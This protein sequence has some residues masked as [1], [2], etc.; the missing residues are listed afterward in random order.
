MIETLTPLE[1]GLLDR[2][3]RDFPL[4]PQPFAVLASA[5]ETDE[6][7]VLAHIVDFRRRGLISRVG[8]V[9]RPNTAGASTLAAMAV[10][11]ARL[12]AV[13][14]RVSAEPAVNHNYER[15]H[16]LNLW[17]VVTATDRAAVATVLA[18][19]VRDS[20]LE[21]LDL[22]L[23]RAY[24]IDLGFSL[25]ETNGSTRGDT[26]SDDV[27]AIE[28]DGADRKLLSVIE[29]GLPLVSRPFS[30][31]AQRLGCSEA[32]VLD[33]LH[34]LCAGG[35]IS[36]FGLIVRHRSL[37]YRA[38]AMAVWNVPDAD[39]DRIAAAFAVQPFVTLCYRRPRRLPRWPYNLFC[40]I[41]GRDREM[42]DG[43]IASLNEIAETCDLP[44][45]VLFSRRYFKQRGARFSGEAEGV[46]A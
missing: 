12:E 22:P 15:E 17:F 41:H 34:R 36:R 45:A 19:I 31:V 21:V 9:V 8:A 23:E 16:E 30:A 43:Q 20:R 42:V 38:N 6:E 13:A 39:V 44:Q 14:A 5:L 28:P 11:P 32:E 29:D 18:G 25:G 37:G 24:H 10:P 33:R 40:M 7:T 27:A 3:Q 2:W 35:V 26:A 46:A 1:L 4:E